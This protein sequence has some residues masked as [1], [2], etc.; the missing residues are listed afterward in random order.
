MIVLGLASDAEIKGRLLGTPPVDPHVNV[1]QVILKPVTNIGSMT[2]KCDS[3]AHPKHSKN[4]RGRPSRHS[5]AEWFR[6]TLPA[7]F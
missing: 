6:F 7:G 5:C 2:L 3:L 4:F 1:L